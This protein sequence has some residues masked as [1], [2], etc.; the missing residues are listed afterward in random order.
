MNIDSTGWYHNFE[1]LGIVTVH[2]SRAH[3]LNQRCKENKI[4]EYIQRASNDKRV[5][6][7]IDLFCND[8]YYTNYG[9]MAKIKMTGIDINVNEIEKAKMI[10][11]A[12]GN[13]INFQIGNVMDINKKYDVIFCFGGLYHL[14]DPVSYLKS[15]K[16]FVKKVL[17]IQTVYF[18]GKSNYF[19]RYLHG[20]RFSKDWIIKEIKKLKYK[21]KDEYINELEANTEKRDR[22]SLYLYCEI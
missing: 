19:S 4:I 20:C 14:K 13:E 3:M 6:T 2:K 16:K 8:G 7:G 21:I 17:I 9:V 12:L 22:G 11:K 5:K 1:R 18:M 10:T 15:L